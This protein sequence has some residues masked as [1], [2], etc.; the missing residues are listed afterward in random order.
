MEQIGYTETLTKYQ[1][2]DLV[3][4]NSG[5]SLEYGYGFFINDVFYGALMDFS[6]IKNT[7]DN[8]L[9]DYRKEYSTD[10]V[11]FVDNITHLSFSL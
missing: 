5:V 2:A 8:L 11:D 6:N 4:Q 9:S 10:L 7:L 1:I 3:L